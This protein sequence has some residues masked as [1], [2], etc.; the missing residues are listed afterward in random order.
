MVSILTKL[1]LRKQ[2]NFNEIIFE[3]CRSCKLKIK[4]REEMEKITLEKIQ[5]ELESLRK[6]IFIYETLQAEKEIKEGKIKGPFKNAKELL[7]HIKNEI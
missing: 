4:M 3:E 6:K 1:F 2:L 5:K 7:K